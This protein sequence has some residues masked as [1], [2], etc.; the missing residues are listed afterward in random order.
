MG[1]ARVAVGAGVGVSLGAGV[2]IDV[3]ATGGRVAVGSV[4]GLEWDVEITLGTA[5]FTEIGRL[6]ADR[7]PAINT[8]EKARRIFMVSP[9]VKSAGKR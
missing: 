1:A 2:G 9:L 5:V 8:I 3:G 4:A 7:K 6:Q